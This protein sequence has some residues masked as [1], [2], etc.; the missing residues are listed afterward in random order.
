MFEQKERNSNRS[1]SFTGANEAYVIE[2]YDQFLKDPSS[3]S[4]Q[5][6]DLFSHWIPPSNNQEAHQESVSAGAGVDYDKVVKLLSL[7]Q[8]IRNIGYMASTLD[9]VS[10][11]PPKAVP[12]LDAATHGL[13]QDDLNRLPSSIIHSRLSAG[14]SS[15]AEVIGKLKQVYCGTTGYDYS[16]LRSPEERAW[17]EEA[18]ESGRFSLKLDPQ[19]K[20]ALLER[21][22]AVEV[23]E[24]FL[25]R[26]FPGQTWFSGEGNDNMILMMDEI[27]RSA[28]SSPIQ[29][30]IM[31]MAHRGRLNVLAHIIDKPYRDVLAEFKDLGLSSNVEVDAQEGVP[32]KD[33]KYHQGAHKQI[34]KAD[35]SA[36]DIILLPNPSHLEM[37]N[38]VVLGATRAIQT[39][40]QNKSDKPS[41]DKAMGVLLH[42]DAAFAGEGIVP[43]SLNLS[44][45]DGYQ[46]GGT[47]HI[48][49]N[50]QLGFT[51]EPEEGHSTPYS[52][53][54][55]RGFDIPVVRV[56]ADDLEAC[57]AAAR[58]SFAYRQRFHKDFL[59]DL[60]GYRRYG[61]NEG[62]EPAFTQPKMYEIIRSHPTAR[63]IF[64]D[65]LVRENVLSAEQAQKI[66]DDAFARWQAALDSLS[67][68][69][70]D[71]RAATA[72][73]PKQRHVDAYTIDTTFPL[74]ILNEIDDQLHKY[75]AD[76]TLNQKLDRPFKRRREL[77]M[78]GNDGRVDWAYA[79]TLAFASI[80][81]EG[82]PIR[83][84]GQDCERGTF[85][86]R[87]AILHDAKTGAEYSPL[88]SM[89]ASKAAF[90]VFNSPLSE[91]AVIAFE[92]GYSVKSPGH[93]VLWEAQYGDFV[94]NAQSVIDEF[95]ASAKTK[96]GQRASLGILLPHAHEGQGPDHTTGFIERFLQLCAD[97]NWRIAYCSSAAQYFHVLRRQAKLAKL[98]PK[99]IVLF[100]AKS[101]LRHPLAS[102]SVSELTNG[103]FQP[104]LDDPQ[105][106]ANASSI[107]K[108]IFCT[109][110]VY[111]D[112]TSNEEYA[113]DERAAVIRIEELYPF[114]AD[115][116]AS[117]LNNY[118][119][120]KEFIWL[121]EETQN[122]G[123]YS[124]IALL[125]QNILKSRGQL[126][127]V[128]RGIRSSPAEG[129]SSMHKM[130]Q[131]RIIKEA[132]SGNRKSV[133]V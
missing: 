31:G 33:V 72:E 93:L 115:H 121:Q 15:A 37:V 11:A 105:R 58:M 128:G 36:L 57:L 8:A 26:T 99:P 30:L 14:T 46:T 22:T 4:P 39:D 131:E 103:S 81:A 132:L 64:A 119:S 97:S 125:L 124:Y 24:Q 116:I 127:Y 41:V 113:K 54:L 25:H 49:I 62:D 10:V 118:K 84:S 117:V 27:V 23:F 60:I 56:N 13:T 55:A 112:V 53:D 86:Q 94:N 50:N 133:M 40:S 52:S 70:K 122:R 80:L 35:G 59:I 98:D 104:V 100:T 71:E 87:H 89:P 90:S 42:G 9:P 95:I 79:E 73:K 29:S 20:R 130:E 67:T 96:W 76:F 65:K 108:L 120:A 114:P 126:A 102:S 110:K 91:E 21:L 44:A 123:A 47:L 111:V 69:V 12:S 74:N 107:Q 2:L 61:H 48:I 43:E 5:L 16:H 66:V 7:V 77:R 83:L 68:V 38:P 75:P 1:I 28:H 6:K 63:A 19:S 45:L 109:G 106:K 17:F 88:K 32:M 101:L 129:S 3:V 82:T 34:K 85:S 51:T 78:Q 92:Y 18:I